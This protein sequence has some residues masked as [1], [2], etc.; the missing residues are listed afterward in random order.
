MNLHRLAVLEITW[1]EKL[2]RER[3]TYYNQKEIMEWF[4]LSICTTYNFIAFL[5]LSWLEIV[6]DGLSLIIELNRPHDN[7]YLKNTTNIAMILMYPNLQLCVI[8]SPCCLFFQ[9][10]WFLN[11]CGMKTKKENCYIYHLFILVLLPCLVNYQ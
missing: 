8:Y 7:F 6:L 9:I 4:I 2:S 1:C 10:K 5:V 11:G 3:S